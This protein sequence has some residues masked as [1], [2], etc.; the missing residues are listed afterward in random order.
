MSW[1]SPGL[2][3]IVTGVPVEELRKLYPPWQFRGLFFCQ[4]FQI[5]V[6]AKG[7]CVIRWDL[8][9]IELVLTDSCVKTWAQGWN[10]N[11]SYGMDVTKYFDR[12]MGEPKINSALIQ[13]LKLRAA[14]Q[15]AED[16]ADKALQLLESWIEE[17][18]KH[19]Q[20][21]LVERAYG[22]RKREKINNAVVIRKQPHGRP[23]NESLMD[24]RVPQ[25]MIKLI[26]DDAASRQATALDILNEKFVEED[27]ACAKLRTREAYMRGTSR[28]WAGYNS[29]VLPRR[30][31]RDKKTKC[32]S[33]G[34]CFTVV[35]LAT[36]LDVLGERECVIINGGVLYKGWCCMFRSL[37]HRLYSFT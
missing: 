2:A 31:G 29:Q 24:R 34:A 4:E 23:T 21:T 37:I 33:T 15:Q 27:A 18:K 16:R 14:V 32:F 25:D 12:Q 3:S 30:G 19:S 36:L 9:G 10:K 1:V 11:V 17:V 20:D 22:L 26:Y 13:A 35:A 6:Q 28:Y 5:S 7:M 8:T